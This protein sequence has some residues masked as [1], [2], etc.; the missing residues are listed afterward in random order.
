MG[1]TALHYAAGRRD[2]GQFY[3]LLTDAGATDDVKDLVRMLA[4]V[5]FQ[6]FRMPETLL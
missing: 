1:R 5:K 6:N 4:T 2:G 3:K